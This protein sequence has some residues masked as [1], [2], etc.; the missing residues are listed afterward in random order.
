LV[1]DD[2]LAFIVSDRMTVPKI[3]LV[4]L[5]AELVWRGS[6][7]PDGKALRLLTGHTGTVYCV[8][9][10]PDGRVLAS[11]SDYG[12][13]RLWCPEP[14]RLS[15]LPLGHT[16]VEDMAWVQQTLESGELSKAGRGWL[17]FLLAM[18]RWRRRFDIGVEEVPKRMAVG[19]FEI[20]I[21][22]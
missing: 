3:L 17:A 22:G 11:G 21:E 4:D 18:M 14:L 9:M 16:S 10:S 6:S 12:T 13:V 19:E 7:V 2:R 1:I 8:A 15:H 5:L 20:E